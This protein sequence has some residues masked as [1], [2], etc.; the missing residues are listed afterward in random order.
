MKRMTSIAVIGAS[1]LA[2]VAPVTEAV[3]QP[4]L[5]E[6]E[7]HAIAVDAYLFFYP[8]ISM[9]VTRLWSTNIEPGKEPLRGPMNTFVSAPAYEFH[10]AAIVQNL[11]TFA[12]RTWR[13]P[14]LKPA[15]CV[16]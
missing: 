16:A 5:T 9:D 1:F 12:I 15:A 8:L 4:P 6:Q 14:P 10:L 13:P 7:A 2:L 3:A 11:K